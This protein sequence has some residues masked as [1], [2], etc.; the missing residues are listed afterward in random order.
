MKNRRVKTRLNLFLGWL[1]PSLI[2]MPDNGI[3]KFRNALA[4]FAR[5]TET[6]AREESLTAAVYNDFFQRYGSTF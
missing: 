3:P 4:S 1:R 2:K 6:T 5:R